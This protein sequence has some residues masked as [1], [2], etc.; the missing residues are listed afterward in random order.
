MPTTLLAGSGAPPRCAASLEAVCE[1]YVSIMTFGSLVWIAV[2]VGIAFPSVG[3]FL[4]SFV[5][6]PSWVDRKWVRLAMTVAAAVLPALVG[7][8]SLLLRDPDERPVGAARLRTVLRGYPFTLGLAV[9]LLMMG[10]DVLPGGDRRAPLLLQA[11]TR[12]P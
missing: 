9:T 6:L 4:L 2:T 8:V 10:G 5:P 12:V 3:T 7:T 1:R 11:G